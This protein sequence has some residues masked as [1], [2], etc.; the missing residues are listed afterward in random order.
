LIKGKNVAASIVEGNTTD[1]MITPTINA[2]Q[3]LRCH[4]KGSARWVLDE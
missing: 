4:Q 2:E 3:P 1:R